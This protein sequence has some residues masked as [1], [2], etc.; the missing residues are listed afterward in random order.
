MSY[1]NVILQ[2]MEMKAGEIRKHS[3]EGSFSFN[4]NPW[5]S[6]MSQ[7]YGKVQTKIVHVT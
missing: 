2:P 6:L 7:A 5:E 3:Y 1:F 4:S